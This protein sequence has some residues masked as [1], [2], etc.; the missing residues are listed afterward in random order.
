[1]ELAVGKVV[2]KLGGGKWG[3]VHDFAPDDGEKR[4]KR[5][6]LVAAVSV[7]IEEQTEQVQAV[8]LGR[9]VLSRL[10][11][12][13]FG[14]V[15]GGA[16]SRL[17]KTVETVS[18]EFEGLEIAAA[19][20]VGQYVYL[21]AGGGAGIWVSAEG[22]RQGWLVKPGGSGQIGQVYNFSGTMSMGKVLVLG[23]R[24]F[25]LQV[26]ERLLSA[27]AAKSEANFSEA[28][29]MLA[30]EVQAGEGGGGGTG[31]MIKMVGS[32]PEVK[33]ITKEPEE[34]V[35][36]GG[37]SGRGRALDKWVGVMKKLTGKVYVK[38]GDK[39]EQRKRAMRGGVVFLVLL[40]VLFGVGQAWNRNK[41]IA[42][43]DR[44][45][46]IEEIIFNFNEAKAMAILNP[47]RSR[48]LLASVKAALEDAINQKSDTR[49][50]Q[51]QEQWQQVWDEA[52]GIVQINPEELL[53]LG[54]VRDEME[55]D[56]MV[57]LDEDLLI[58]DSDSGR[59]AEI[60]S[61]TGSGKILAGS[62]E[63]AGA[64][65][66]AAYPGRVMVMGADNIWEVTGEKTVSVIDDEEAL[67]EAVDIEMWA[68]NVYLL[69]N[70][71]GVLKVWRYQ[72]SGA[73]FGSGQEWLDEGSQTDL[74]MGTDMAIDGSIWVVGESGVYKF[75]RGVREDFIMTGEDEAPEIID[76]ISTDE[77]AENLYLWEKNKG[78][79]VVIS[80]E[81]EYKK[82]LRGEI[83]TRAS[84][85]V[86]DETAGKGYILAD[87]SVWQINL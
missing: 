63:L 83:L 57:K 6:R 53:D 75:I 60:N 56:K 8:A 82:Q 3:Q 16:M 48:E 43:S 72:A 14:E 24:G 27:A 52:A 80:K 79:V 84:D 22:A 18:G 20:F 2:G 76:G 28:V 29:E 25:W 61:E 81:G 32:E 46:I 66:L 11:E 54:L 86:I 58:L 78:R 50:T 49:L 9:E 70:S 51:I 31:V 69:T 85:V 64:K 36:P 71:N 42:G 13:Y 45:K 65:D 12:L 33:S 68:S 4:E 7:G 1:M 5:G 34:K 67:R 19:A 87:G 30:S 44:E 62:D 37:D 38:P 26:S 74:S 39:S 23:T 59:V 40:L 55:G 41:E 21:A 77:N 47:A 10:Q 15:E 17:V 35:R 73:G